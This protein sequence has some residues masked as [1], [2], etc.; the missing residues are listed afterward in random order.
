MLQRTLEQNPMSE[1]IEGTAEDTICLGSG[2]AY[3]QEP[4]R[5]PNA[6]LFW[7]NF[8]EGQGQMW[9]HDLKVLT[10]RNNM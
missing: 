3:E 7:Q 4:P 1:K 8:A 5:G 2:T 6:R 9:S 10:A